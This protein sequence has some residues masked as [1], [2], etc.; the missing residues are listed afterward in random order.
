MRRLI[1]L[2]AITVLIAPVVFVKGAVSDISVRKFDEFGDIKCED[3]YA[4]LDNFVLALRNEPNARGVIIFYGG[5]MFR[6]RLPRRN[7]A[8]ARAARIKPYLVKMR[9][10]P[11]SRIIVVNGGYDQEWKAEL[12]IMSPAGSIPKPSPTLDANE[13]KFRKG[14]VSPRAFRCGI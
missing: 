8:A 3:E 6:S 9:G 10:I 1:G 13:I 14:R 11:D 2:T 4:R 12:W 5:R 7:D